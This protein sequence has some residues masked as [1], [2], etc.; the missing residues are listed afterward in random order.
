MFPINRHVLQWQVTIEYDSRGKR[1]RKTLNDS[2]SSRQYEAPKQSLQSKHAPK[3][4]A[5]LLRAMVQDRQ[6][7]QR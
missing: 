6:T 4:A 1:M 2:Y 7:N 5:F 3:L